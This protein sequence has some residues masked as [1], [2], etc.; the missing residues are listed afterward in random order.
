[1]WKTRIRATTKLTLFSISEKIKLERDRAAFMHAWIEEGQKSWA[2]NDD[3]RIEREKQRLRYELTLIARADARRENDRLKHVNEGESNV[4]D[5]ERNMKRLGVGNDD[6]DSSNYRSSSESGLNYLSRIEQKIEGSNLKASANFE[7]MEVLK[8]TEK[9]NKRARKE[10]ETRRRKMI[11]DQ[12]KAQSEL[13][14]REAHDMM[15]EG[16][17]ISAREMREVNERAWVGKKE[18][19]MLN[20]R[21]MNNLEEKADR[22]TEEADGL[23]QDFFKKSQIEN[24]KDH[25]MLE[26]K[27]RQE[28]IDLLKVNAK[29]KKRVTATSVSEAAIAKLIDAVEVLCTERETVGGPVAPQF[30]R[31]ILRCFVSNQSFYEDENLEEVDDFNMFEES[32]GYAEGLK[33]HSGLPDKMEY[34][35]GTVVGRI[36]PSVAHSTLAK[37]CLAGI[38]RDN[39]AVSDYI[40]WTL[41][42]F[43]R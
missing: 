6:A 18:K 42:E 23:L 28:E 32:V 40:N 19:A 22:R 41:H 1:M 21:K 39:L 15:M 7:T 25:K 37:S 30:Y 9:I 17:A 13:H 11:V 27:Q 3:I 2:V 29:K 4:N 10:R 8:Q 16:L 24:K 12:N 33:L 36:A 26:K 31:D 14:K 20:N 38:C 43:A 35:E 5:F 34:G